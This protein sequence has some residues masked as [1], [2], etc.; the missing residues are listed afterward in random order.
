MERKVPKS[1]KYANVS[2]VL[3]TGLTINKVKSVT[4][5]EYAKRR[6]EIFFRLT[7]T[8]LYQLYEEYE[9]EEFESITENNRD[10]SVRIVTYSENEMPVYAKPYLLLDM[11]EIDEF[12]RCHLMQARS[13]PYS[14]LRRDQYHPEIYRYRNQ[15]EKLIVVYC[16]DE[17]MSRLAAKDLVDRGIDNVFLLTGGLNEFSYDYPAF[18]EG[19]A[20]TPPKAKTMPKSRLTRV[21]EDEAFAESSLKG[22]PSPGNRLTQS[23]LERHNQTYGPAASTGRRS[24]GSPRGGL[25]GLVA[26]SEAGTQQSSKSG[27]SCS[28]FYYTAIG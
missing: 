3:D 17:R 11:R 24:F 18:V 4:A 6:D 13:Y 19:Q 12:N 27:M 10:E 20:P 28:S 16:S 14:Y 1:S 23:K 22:P 7:K 9:Q 21:V 2:G 25:A 5:R 8:Q 15:A 26:R